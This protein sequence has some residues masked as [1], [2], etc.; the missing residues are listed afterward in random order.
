MK[1]D[2]TM[3]LEKR[4]QTAAV[5]YDAA[6]WEELV[7]LRFVGAGQ[8]V[9]ALGPVGVGKTFLASALGHIVPEEAS[10]KLSHP[11]DRLRRAEAPPRPLP[12]GR[13]PP[14]FRARSQRLKKKRAP[15]ARER[16]DGS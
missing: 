12:G 5:T 14:L 16:A 11:G 8:D 9:L 3:V 10:C 15:T 7:T 13:R 4:D 2:L 6:T 1:L